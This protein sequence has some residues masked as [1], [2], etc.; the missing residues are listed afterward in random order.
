SQFKDLIPLKQRRD[1][2]DT[3]EAIPERPDEETIRATAQRTQLALQKA[4]GDRIGAGTAKSAS[5]GNAAEPVFVRYTPNQQG[6]GFNSGA[7]QRIVRVSEMPADPLAPPKVKHQ[8]DV[9]APA[10][11]PAP[12]MHSPPR[13][14]TAEEQKEWSIPPCVSNWKNIHG[15]TISLDKR[16]ATDGRGLEQV[17]VNDNF[18]KLSEALISAESHAREE[19]AQRARMQQNLARREKEAKEEKLRM[20]AQKAREERASAGKPQQEPAHTSARSPS[21]LQSKTLVQ[22]YSS[23]PERESD[24]EPSS[25]RAKVGTSPGPAASHR[26]GRIRMAAADYFAK[27]EDRRNTGRY[28]SKSRSRSRSRSPGASGGRR[29]RARDEHSDYG[30]DESDRRAR[31]RDELRKERRKQHERELRLSRMGSD[32][33]AKYLRKAESRDISE[34]IALGIAKPTVSRESMFDARLFNQP[35]ASNSALQNDEA[36]NVYDKPLFNPAARSSG[37]YRPRGINE[38]EGRASEVER[39]MESDRFGSSLRGFKGAS[40]GKASKPRNAP[41]EFEKGDVFGIDAFVGESRNG[42][43]N[44]K[45]ALADFDGVVDAQVSLEQASV[46]VEWDPR[47]AGDD[48]GAVIGVIEDCGFDVTWK[49]PPID[50]SGRAISNAADRTMVASIAVDGM[51]CHSC[52]KSVTMALEDTA[53]VVDAKV[54][55][56]PRGLAQVTFNAHQTGEQA[57]I[58]AIEDAGFD[59]TLESVASADSVSDNGSAD[60]VLTPLQHSSAISP[61]VESHTTLESKLFSD[62]FGADEQEA[63]LLSASSPVSRNIREKESAASGK[64]KSKRSNHP[65]YSISSSQSGDTLVSSAIGK[66]S[67]SS[68][69]SDIGTTSQFEVHGMTC[70]SCVASIERGLKRKTGIVAVSVSLLAQRATVQFDDHIVSDD[71]IVGWIEDLGFEAKLFNESPT[72]AKISL[73]VYGMTCASCVASIERAVKREP[74][75]V[76]VS[77]SLALE[78]AAIEY[79]PSEIGVRKLVAAIESAGFDVLVAETTKNT[80]QLDSLKRTK[81]ILAWR[82]RFWKSL[83]FSIPVIFIAKITPHIHVLHVF[84]MTQILPGLPLGALCQLILTTPLQFVIGARFYQNAF[85][86]LRHGNANMDVLVTTGTSLSYFF[87]LFMLLWSLLHGKHPHPHC[88][89]EAPAMLIT[90]V[91]LGRYLENMAKGNASAAL[92]TLMTLTPTQA[93]LVTYDKD[94]R[95]ANEKQ[96]PTELIQ[97]GDHLRVFPGERVPADGTLIEGSSEV[98]ESTVTGEALPVRK[99]AGSML[100]AGTVNCTGSFTMKASRVGAET[101]LS[102]IV[103]LVE[104]AQTAKAPIQ[105]YADKVAQYFAP[106]V[107][108]ISLVTFIGWVIVSYTSLPKP[109]MFVAEANET[110]SYMVGCLKIAVAVV[111]VACPCA[112]GLSTPTAVMV[113]TGVGAQM[114]VLIKGGE[115]LEAASHIDVVVFDK[116]G[117]L[118]QGKLAVADM[119]FVPSVGGLHLTQRSFTLLAGA[120][121]SGSEHPLGKAVVSYAQTLLASAPT[122]PALATEFDSVPGQ[123]IRCHVTPDLSAGADYASE[124][125]AGV[126]VLVGS[127]AF[128]ESQGSAIPRS[129]IDDKTRQERNGRTVVLVAIAGE[130]AGWLALSDVLR[131]EAIP[132]IA[133]LQDS[134]HTECV[135]VT[136]DQPL[137]AQAV[138]A[139]C[140]IRRVYAGVSPAGKAAIIRQLQSETTVAK[141]GMLQRLFCGCFG[142]RKLAKKRVAMVGDG[143]NDG[144]ALAAAEVGIAM[145]SGTDVAMEAATMVLMREDVADVVAA[146][147]LSRTIFRRIQWNYI[148][149]SMYNMLGIPL[150]MGLFMPVGIM[151]PPVFAGLAMAM[152][153]LSVM[154]SSLLLKLYKKPICHAPSPASLPLQPGDVRVMAAPKGR[155]R[156]TVNSNGEFVVDLSATIYDSD[157]SGGGALELDVLSNPGSPFGGADALA[158]GS[159]KPSKPTSGYFGFSSSKRGYEQ[160]SQNV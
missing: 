30:N 52:V 115:A 2:D 16:L 129:C 122:L 66:A 131:A 12:V 81:D 32:A 5:R 29:S 127:A 134:M 11:P 44:I 111:V 14:L 106:A 158:S 132:T 75:I 38:D 87:S 4:V 143:V 41:V 17:D 136:G 42:K 53:G 82:T 85:K 114:G 26:G 8:K 77:V 160:L 105:A 110:G 76:S 1:F 137:T 102:Q 109:A 74:G 39:M 60:G 35:S 154:A 133:T 145:R 84:F 88:F 128:L 19:I 25:P 6:A 9:R 47:V 50:T 10:E 23:S 55:L 94:G 91:S 103:K 156:R 112:L 108:L 21:P 113:G 116:T 146:L 24:S 79:R 147:D 7:S 120:A 138:A 144:A 28:S 96:I 62:G 56:K 3:Q 86:A 125:G 149:A 104:E 121:E 90:F 46:T 31:E 148:W 37:S 140:G 89:F 83:W 155:R 139:E 126:E 22:G 57:I 141:A 43:D 69:S 70:T 61:G 36:Y 150:A 117:T 78:T 99:T 151:M 97:S 33:K 123:G 67:A 135:M 15:F 72:V 49:P 27:E 152:S 92:S 64:K 124:F 13:R 48:V 159:G 130:Y 65:S 119:D 45:Q 93:T 98:D 63:P 68:S 100:V 153:S 71:D 34:K 20:L 18:A 80:T 40:E 59:A 142:R 58:A 73:N 101:T 95:V 54:E 51:T 107:M 118:T 157:D